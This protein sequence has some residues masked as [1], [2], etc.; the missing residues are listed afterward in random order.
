MKKLAVLFVVMFALSGAVSLVSAQEKTGKKDKK[1]LSVNDEMERDATRNLQAIRLYFDLRKAYLASL[2]RCEEVLA[3]Y[4]TYSKID[5]VLYY[6]GQSSLRLSKGE[7]KQK[8]KLSPKQ[9]ADDARNYFSQLVKEHPDS[10]FRKQAE[11]ALKGVGGEKP[12]SAA[13]Q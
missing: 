5:E 3:A 10:K 11:T 9:Y 1:E 7:G 2:S 13:K 4:P 8:S 12:S 6:A